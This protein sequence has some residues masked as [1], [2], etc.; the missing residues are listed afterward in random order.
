M[1][2]YQIQTHFDISERNA[3]LLESLVHTVQDIQ[4]SVVK[5][6]KSVNGQQEMLQAIHGQLAEGRTSHDSDVMKE[7]M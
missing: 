5:I 6:K 2:I 1:K 3:D 4:K 7:M